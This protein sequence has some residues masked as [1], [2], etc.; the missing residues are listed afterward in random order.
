MKPSKSLL[1]MSITGV[2]GLT[3]C[4]G[5]NSEEPVEPPP[6]AIPPPAPEVTVT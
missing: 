2:L 5:S 4:G 6:V 3:G 1:L